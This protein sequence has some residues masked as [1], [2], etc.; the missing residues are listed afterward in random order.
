L[1]TPGDS[2]DCDL[3]P[4]SLCETIGKA[5]IGDQAAIDILERVIAG[6]FHLPLK[7]TAGRA[8]KAVLGAN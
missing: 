5:G 3:S 2:P 1:A 8:L 6:T 4:D 7:R